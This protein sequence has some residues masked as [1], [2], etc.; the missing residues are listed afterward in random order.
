MLEIKQVVLWGHKL[1]SHTHSYIHGAFVKAFQYR[2]YKTL[3]LDNNDNIDNID[4]SGS[5]FITE[6]NVDNNIPIRD[7]CY[8]VLHNCD[9]SKYINVPKKN[10]IIIQV[11]TNSVH[12]YKPNKIDNNDYCYYLNECLYMPWGT[13]LLPEEI[14]L[15]IEKVKNNMLVS[16]N[17]LYFIGMT[18]YPW[19]EV[20]RFCNN[21][22][23]EYINKGGFLG[24]NISFNENMKLIQKSII[25]PAVQEKWQTDNGYIPCR[26]FKNISYGKMGVTNNNTVYEL[27]DKKILFNT[28][29]YELMNQAVNFELKDTEYK[30]SVLVPLME[31]VRDKHTYLNRVDLII[32]FLNKQE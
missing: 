20:S 7:D 6:G 16:E 12:K 17:K 13:D 10:K 24:N 2:G 18:L 9:G 23:I 21:N 32:W 27:F 8:Y 15:N 26:I 19:D 31:Y 29:V 22:K 4:F 1:H 11:Y 28:N 14:N 30:K 25:A 5:L 3:W